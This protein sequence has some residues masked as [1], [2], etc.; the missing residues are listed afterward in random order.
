V[1]YVPSEQ[2]MNELVNSIQQGTTGDFRRRYR[3]IDL[4]LVDDVHFLEQK[5]RTQEEFFHTFN[6]LYDAGKQIVLT[7][8]RPP[9]ELPGVEETAWCPGSSGG[10]WRTSSPRLRDPHCDPAGRRRTTTA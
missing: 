4:L 8:D 6:A 9:K 5:E 7:S 1:A 10:W 3:Q 2:F